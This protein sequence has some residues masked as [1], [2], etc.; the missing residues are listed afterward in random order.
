[1]FVESK[2]G[3]KSIWSS[4]NHSSPCNCFSG[5]SGHI[6][7]LDFF[8]AMLTYLIQMTLLLLGNAHERNEL[9][10]A[11][12]YV[13]GFRSYTSTADNC[14]AI[15]CALNGWGKQFRKGELIQRH[16]EQINDSESSWVIGLKGG[17][18]Q[19]NVKKVKENFITSDMICLDRKS[20]DNIKDRYCMF[21]DIVLVMA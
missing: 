7:L 9:Q 18:V 2:K 8:G 13:C 10:C 11:L 12:I 3:S 19:W 21:F 4:L 16:E 15:F 14:K 5:A 20:L 17:M 6:D 1:M